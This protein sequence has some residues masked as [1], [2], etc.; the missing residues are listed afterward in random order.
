MLEHLQEVSCPECLPT[1]SHERGWLLSLC[2]SSE[3]G[4]LDPVTGHPVVPCPLKPETIV[5]S[6]VREGEDT[7]SPF[8]FI[9]VDKTVLMGCF[10][11]PLV[12]WIL[13][14]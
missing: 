7:A 8:A 2:N 3:Q 10:T 12:V 1:W 5:V 4:A 14:V 13:F 9:I 11:S 6:L